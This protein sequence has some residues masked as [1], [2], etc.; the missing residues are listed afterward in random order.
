MEKFLNLFILLVVINS[1]VSESSK[2]DLIPTPQSSIPSSQTQDEINSNINFWEDPTNPYFGINDEDGNQMN[3]ST[4]PVFAQTI[5][6]FLNDPEI[7]S[8]ILEPENLAEMPSLLLIFKRR[9][10][11]GIFDKL[12]INFNFLRHHSFYGRQGHIGVRNSFLKHLEK[13]LK[14]K[15]I[16]SVLNEFALLKAIRKTDKGNLDK[17]NLSTRRN[18]RSIP[19]LFN[20]FGDGF[21]F[22]HL[23]KNIGFKPI[24]IEPTTSEQTTF[25]TTTPEPTPE[26]TTSKSIDDILAEI[27]PSQ[28][29]GNSNI[30]D[31]MSGLV[32]VEDEKIKKAIRNAIKTDEADNNA[33]RHNYATPEMKSDVIYIQKLSGSMADNIENFLNRININRFKVI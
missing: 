23:L 33:R 17:I 31:E 8:A 3:E 20:L 22:S 13:K 15:D 29:A 6:S 28:L 14:K 30:A 1:V 7:I 21:W 5:E 25:D 18:K 4:R 9:L 16:G 27:V 2:S 10:I 19:T 32:E 12:G 11:H 24:T 26:P